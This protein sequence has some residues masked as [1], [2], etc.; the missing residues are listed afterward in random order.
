M[1]RLITVLNQ[2]TKFK[3]FVFEESRLDED[4][5]ILVSLRSRKNS[6]GEY[7]DC[8]QL[9]PTYDTATDARR[10]E[11]VPVWGFSVFLVYR[12][13]R[14]ACNACGRVVIEKVPWSTGKHHLTDIYRC[15]L[16]QWAKKLS[17]A[18]VARSFR[19]SWDKVYHSVQY[20]VEYGLAHRRLDQ[21][22]AL[23][24]D[25]I[26]S[27]KGHHFLTL[28]YQIDPHRRRLL[29]MGEKRTKKTM[30][31]GFT[32]LEQ[33]H[34]RKQ[35]AD[36]VEE[37]TS[38]L[39]Q[40]AFICSDLWKAYLTVIGQRLP[41]AVHMLDRFHLMQCFS[42]ALDKVRAEEARRLKAEGK[43]PVLSKSRWCFLKRKENLTDHTGF[44][45]VRTL[46]DEP[47][48]RQSLPPDGG[49]PALL[50]LHLPRLGREIPPALVFPHDEKQH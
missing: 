43:D 5:R 7:S 41:A 12:M 13:R 45:A 29:W 46:D 3:R 50:G 24:V 25:E 27:R 4:G 9:S 23:G 14:V 6:R 35:E 31:D 17:W 18:E 11:F 30:D 19:T 39:D 8:G 42:K 22:T 20:V 15:F 32:E 49:L 33:E 10:F 40:I 44:E 47:A 36:D 1:T 16:A 34:Q 37:P 2:C 28:L 21:V 48:D 38:F 26:Q